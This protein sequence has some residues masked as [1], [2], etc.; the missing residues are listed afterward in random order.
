MNWYYNKYVYS[1]GHAYLYKEGGDKMYDSFPTPAVVID[2]D[3]VDRNIIKMVESNNKYGI[4]HRPHIKSHKSLFIAKRQLELGAQG[5]TCAKLG[6]AEVMVDG[7][8]TDILIAYP[9]IGQDKIERLSRLMD[10]ANI[11]TIVNS[12]EGAKALSQLGQS[13]AKKIAV[14]IDVDGGINR[15][16]HKPLEPTLKFA[17]K[18][19]DLKGIDIVG[20]MYYSGIIYNEVTKE[21][22]EDKA[23]LERDEIINTAKLLEK[24]G[25]NM[26]VLSAGNS[27][28]S[29]MPHLLEGV[30]EVRAGHY[31]FND[32]GQLLTGFATED[33]CALKVIS[34]VVSVVDSHHA[35]IDAGSKSLT[36]D[37]CLH[38]KGYGYVVGRPD[39]Y[40][41]Q[42]NEEHGFIESEKEIGLQVGDK[43]AIIP[44]HACVVTNLVDEAYGVRNGQLEKMIKIDAR[45]KNQ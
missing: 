9:I 20:L 35:I 41:S 21:G 42:L 10:R 23:K 27:F 8:I 38:R 14:L 25:F 12:E 44:N 3:Q 2:L 11:V 32:C 17:Q 37:T 29:K 19:R 1:I 24:H 16:G 43:I 6:E 5:I 18:I 22:F 15:G 40:I 31:V 39:I 28:S 26:S 34:T 13:K 7:G 36:S 33:E 30:T 45:G 4:N